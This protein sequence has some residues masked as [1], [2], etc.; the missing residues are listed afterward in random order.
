MK[1]SASKIFVT[2]C[3]LF[4]SVFASAQKTFTWK[5]YGVSVTLPSDFT[6]V[7]NTADEFECKGIGMDF[8]M[9]PF[10]DASVTLKDMVNAT[11]QIAKEMKVD[12]TDESH[13]VHINGFEGQYILGYKDGHQMMI[14]G[15]INPNN[16][17]NL[18][19][20]ILFEDGDHHAESDGVAILNSLK[21]K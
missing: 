1:L 6:V 14:C 11:R 19:I 9:L 10:Q 7:T 20:Y 3:I 16:S 18:L 8:H 13:E 17:T 2:F 21:M 4:F 12:A 5:Q 15:L